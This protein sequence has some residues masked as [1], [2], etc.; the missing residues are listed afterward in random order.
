[1]TDDHFL[2]SE[3]ITAELFSDLLS[4]NNTNITKVQFLNQFA[5]LKL[6]TTE[7]D[8]FLNS[9]Q[10][11]RSVLSA[12]L[13]AQQTADFPQIIENFQEAGKAFI[14]SQPGLFDF[15]SDSIVTGDRE[16]QEFFDVH[17]EMQ[18]DLDYLSPTSAKHFFE[19]EFPALFGRFV[20]LIKK[21]SVRA[22]A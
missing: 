10:A 18:R 3:Y 14:S 11:L 4:Q 9:V 7:L 12:N 1:M 15:E 22:S 13:S 2:P 5:T 20:T 8:K 6:E 19:N 17:I 16:N 21:A